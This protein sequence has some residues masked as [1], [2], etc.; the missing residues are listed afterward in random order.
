MQQFQFIKSKVI[1]FPL[2]NVDTDMIMPAQFMTSNVS[3]LE[4]W[5]EKLFFRLKTDPDFVFNLP[6][7]QGA[8]ILVAQDNFGCGSSREHAVWALQGSGIRVIIAPSFSDIF[9]NNS[10]KNGLV[11]V[12]LEE[13][14]VEEILTKAE[15]SDLFL[16][17][18]LDKQEVDLEGWI[19]HFDFDPFKKECILEG[20]SD[21]AY[22]EKY[23]KEILA[24][25]QAQQANIFLNF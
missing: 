12:T 2:V 23:S 14:L 3:D 7:Y 10:S 11:L 16:S 25:D 6:K 13:K 19:L 8:Q 17:V 9:Y 20:L 18:D 24:W 15:N 4:F 1:P 5:G 21:M 22:L